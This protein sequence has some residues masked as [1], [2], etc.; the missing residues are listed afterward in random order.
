MATTSGTAATKGMSAYDIARAL[1]RFARDHGFVAPQAYYIVGMFNLKTKAGKS[2]YSDEAHLWCRDC[3]E[4]LLKRAHRLM[5]KARRADHFICATDADFEDTCPHCMACGET[6]QGTVS[7]YCVEEEL[8][9]YAEHPITDGERVNPRQAV[10]IAMVVSA[11]PDDD[12]ALRLGRAA[13]S[14]AGGDR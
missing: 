11:A 9:H 10:E 4:K 2:V 13:L 3:A 1:E 14:K 6:L 5:P 12:D 7:S 8:A